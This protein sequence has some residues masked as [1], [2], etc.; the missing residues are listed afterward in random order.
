[1][2][3]GSPVGTI[4]MFDY[5]QLRYDLL[6]WIDPEP[7]PDRVERL[8]DDLERGDYEIYMHKVDSALDEAHQV[9]MRTGVSSMLKA[10]D[11]VVGVHTREG[12]LVSASCG[13]YLHGP[14]AQLPVKFIVKHYLEGDSNVEVNP[15]DIFYTNEVLTGGLHNPDQM[16]IMPIFHEGE[17]V[18]WASA[19]LHQGETGAIEPGGMAQ[20]ARTR[21]DEGM[22]LTPIKIAE[23]Y[24]IRDDLMDMM[25]NFIL[26]APQMQET[27]VRARCTAVDVIR[28]RVQGIAEE[29]DADFV[30]GLF[31][32]AITEA[33]VGARSLVAELTDG[34]YRSV[35][36]FDNIGAEEALM[37]ISLELRKEGDT[38]TL[39][40][41]GT[42]PEAGS[43]N[44]FAHGV[45]AYISSYLYPYVF[46]DLPVSTGAFAPFE[47]EIPDRSVLNASPE[48]SVSQCVIAGTVV[49]A[50]CHDVFG[51]LLYPTHPERVAG[52]PDTHE[53]GGGYAGV[54]KYGVKSAD[55]VAFNM[56][57]MGAG[58]RVDRDGIDAHGFSYGPWG[59]APNME[60]DEES[61][62]FL[63]IR[64][65]F[66][67]D[68]GGFGKFRGGDGTQ[69]MNVVVSEEPITAFRNGKG[70]RIPSNTGLFGGYAESCLVG[71]RVTDTDYLER[72]RAGDDVPTDVRELVAERSVDGEYHFEPVGRDSRTSERGDLFIRLMGG[73]GGLG[74]PLERDA[75]AV[76]EDVSH[77]MTSEW[78][79]E[80]VYGVAIDD[81][82]LDEAAT[83]RRREAERERRLERGEPFEAFEAE[84]E[85]KRPDEEILEYYGQ[86]PEGLL[87]RAPVPADD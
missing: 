86:W 51:R 65:G 33:E 61:G 19:A 58:A 55:M 56:N 83:E 27:D 57:T 9:F 31:R 29:T 49:L 85:T 62:I 8:A 66:L 74:D 23:D 6:D 39:D 26:R 48:A 7:A 42:S 87:E 79:A 16:A 10:G 80:S 13:T 38:V 60:D 11:V 1:M 21:Y 32:R 3:P 69:N 34:T 72:F 35:G 77:G 76:V 73:G 20:S 28:K 4:P 2:R 64:R 44:S 67:A 41:S 63:P 24:E 82:D 78:A 84:W 53:G 37:K 14:I 54:D 50:R 68:S 52:P 36:F 22:R 30:H 15:G 59:K 12:D 71:L 18:S 5:E 40:F 45:V 47:F 70:T 25:V 75:E 17:L 81:G 43:L 46:Y